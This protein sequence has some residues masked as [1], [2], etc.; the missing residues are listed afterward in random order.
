MSYVILLISG[1]FAIM[2]GLFHFIKLERKSKGCSGNST[3]KSL[4]EVHYELFDYLSR[5]PA[6]SGKS[7]EDIQSLM[8]KFS[9][10]DL[11]EISFKSDIEELIKQKYLINSFSSK[12]EDYVSRGYNINIDSF[13]LGPKGFDILENKKQRERID[14]LNSSMLILASISAF[15]GIMS[16]SVSNDYKIFLGIILLIIIFWNINN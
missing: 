9:D 5:L 13:K 4:M 6:K 10:G 1:V 15:I 14:K 3:E 12:L 16:P 8:I 2:T 11:N 7:I